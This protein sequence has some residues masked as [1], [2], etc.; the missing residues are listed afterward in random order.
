MIGSG[1][2]RV[3]GAA[4]LALALAAALALSACGG[5]TEPTVSGPHRSYTVKVGASFPARQRLAQ[6]SNLIVRVTNTGAATLPNVA[7]TLTNPKY[8]TAAQALGTLLPPTQQGQGILQNRSRPIWIIDQ[9]PGPCGYSCK[10]LG[11]GAGAT[12]YSNTWALGRLEPHQT[13]TFGWHVTAVQPGSFAIRYQ[14]AGDLQGG[15]RALY[16]GGRAAAGT[17]HVTVSG[18]PRRALVRPNGQVVYSN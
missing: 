1:L 7:V 13:I 16:T 18:V 3:G 10:Q 8:G 5:T 14:I 6:Q 2:N 17:L 4:A 15:A 9:A 11:P 12:A